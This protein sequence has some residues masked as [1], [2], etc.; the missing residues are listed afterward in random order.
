MFNSKTWDSE[1][2]QADGLGNNSCTGEEGREHLYL[3][4]QPSSSVIIIRV[5]THHQLMTCRNFINSNPH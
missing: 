2:W 4:Y 3:A 5:V 1:Y